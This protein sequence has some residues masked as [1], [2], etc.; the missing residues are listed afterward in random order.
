MAKASKP[1]GSRILQKFSLSYFVLM[2][3]PLVMSVSCFLYTQHLVRTNVSYQNELIIAA[4]LERIDNSLGESLNFASMLYQQANLR[5]LLRQSRYAQATPIYDI[6]RMNQLLPQFRD[7]NGLVNEYF[8]VDAN[9]RFL[10]AYRHAYIHLERHYDNQLAVEG[11]NYKAWRENVLSVDAGFGALP[12]YRHIGLD[13]K[14]KTSIPYTVS[15]LDIERGGIHGKILFFMDTQ[16]LG[17]LLAPAFARGV[18]EV[19]IINEQGALLY[20]F[21]EQQ[22]LDLSGTGTDAFMEQLLA[23]REND[24]ITHKGSWQSGWTIYTVTP[25]GVIH[26]QLRTVL[27]VLSAGMALLIGVGLGLTTLVM[28]ANRRPLLH[29]MDSLPLREA[30][31]QRTS[32]SLWNLNAAVMMLVSDRERLQ[33]RLEEQRQQLKNASLLR[34]IQGG[35]SDEQEIETLLAHADVEIM[36]ERHRGIYLKITAHEGVSAPTLERADFIRSV[37]ME[38]LSRFGKALT[39]LMLHDQHTIILLYTQEDPANDC[40]LSSTL[41]PLYQLLKGTYGVDAV[42]Y[43]GMACS[44]LRQLNRSF[45]QARHLMENGADSED[46]YY[47]VVGD[48]DTAQAACYF[49]TPGDEHQLVSLAEKGKY[50]EIV[51]VLGAIYAK[52]FL[53]GHIDDFWQQLLYA[54]MIDTLAANQ[55]F[56]AELQAQATVLLDKRD[57]AFFEEIA[58]HYRVWCTESLDKIGQSQSSLIQATLSYMAENYADCNM[59]LANAALRL[60]VTESHLSAFFKAKTGTTFSSHLEN[61][62]MERACELLCDTQ[63]SIEEISLAVGYASVHSFR[64]AYRRVRGY[65]PSQYRERHLQRSTI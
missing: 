51:S 59:G 53:E 44:E 42:F 29:M 21:N 14:V 57:C 18:S 22:A 27:G 13:G 61:L 35:A 12:A 16:R 36:G 3:V 62:R 52:N 34:I 55:R 64:R 25:K 20:A 39:Y 2:L 11:M 41:A 8:I 58:K 40:L 4:S 48:G 24:V 31:D 1:V 65:T 63:M 23:N 37:I 32:G 17:A 19:Y 49:Y 56:A 9:A 6:Y 50:V 38:A 45:A 54:R 60:G 7:I 26:R 30:S 46:S 28:R 5:S 43:V 10:L 33:A 47:F 15:Y